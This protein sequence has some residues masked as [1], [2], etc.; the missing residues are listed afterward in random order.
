[1][2]F[3]I[4][5]VN[6]QEMVSRAVKGSSNNKLIPLTS[7]MAI[8]LEKGVLTLTTTDG[9]NYLYIRQDKVEGED[10]YVVVG[11]EK[12]SKL[13]SRMTCEMVKLQL[14][15]NALQITGN[16]SYSIDLPLDEDGELIKYPNPLAD[17]K[18][19]KEGTWNHST[20]TTILNSIKPS[21][22]LTLENPC[23]TGYYVGDKIV[24]TD[25]YKIACLNASLFKSSRLISAE[26]MNLLSVMQAEKINVEVVKDVVIFSTPDC[27]VYGEIMDGIDDFAI[28][29]IT[30]LVDTDFKSMCKLPKSALLQ[31]LDRLSLFVGA[32]DKNCVRMTFTKEGLQ[33]SS[34][35]ESGVEI[36]EY[37]E[38]RKFK[39]FTCEI[40]IEM[41][42][43]QLKSQV[44]DVVELWYGLDN[45]IKLVDGDVVQ[46]IALVEDTDEEE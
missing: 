43:T 36:I 7:L 4:K 34:K 42:I 20:V 3:E 12:F 11:V 21:L 14:N 32:Y 22:A 17:V 46:I 10:F 45:A 28:D 26:M 33:I 35:A 13:I 8:N 29:A 27:V 1:M 31:L 23:Y 30:G 19:K 41:F 38:S 39:A 25:T 44:G 40:D 18:P 5:T 2:K 15:A 6:L 16:G 24:A 9:T 37:R